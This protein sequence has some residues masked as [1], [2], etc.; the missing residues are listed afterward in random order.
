MTA[1]RVL[2]VGMIVILGISVFSTVWTINLR[3][4]LD[5]TEKSFQTKLDMIERFSVVPVLEG[6]EMRTIGEHRV[7][8]IPYDVK[9]SPEEDYL[10]N[11]YR[12]ARP[13]LIHAKYEHIASKKEVPFHPLEWAHN[14]LNAASY[15]QQTNKLEESR[16]LIDTLVKQA[17][18][19]AKESGSAWYLG[20]PFQF[21]LADKTLENPWFSGIAQAYVMAAWIR[22]YRVT[23]ETKFKDLAEKT[24]R[25]FLQIRK[26]EGQKAPWVS[27]VDKAGYLWFEE[28]PSPTDP[29]PRVLNG[30]ICAIMG[31]YSYYRLEPNP[32]TLALIRAGITTVSRYFNEFRRPGS[33]PNY[34]LIGEYADYRPARAVAQQEWLYKITGDPYLKQAWSALKTDVTY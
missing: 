33:T 8:T 10:M 25:S 31:L 26:K 13:G 9:F 2:I 3:N 17:M 21:R 7:K 28:Y 12:E 32:E 15:A 34:Y 27:F 14:V 20:Y 29:Q 22:L 24:Y 30:H 11:T 23:G 18:D 19:Y 16:Q 6:I 5:R 4:D 1:S